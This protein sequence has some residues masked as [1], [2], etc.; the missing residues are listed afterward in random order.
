MLT[1]IWSNVRPSAQL[2][3]LKGSFMK[4]KIKKTLLFILF[5]IVGATISAKDFATVRIK[6]LDGKS[7]ERR[8]EMI[9]VSEGV[10]RALPVQEA[11]ISA[12]LPIRYIT[13]V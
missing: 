7:G 3:V 10:K 9:E 13:M 1:S 12:L 8:V 6:Y 5:A 11:F 4:M 2:E